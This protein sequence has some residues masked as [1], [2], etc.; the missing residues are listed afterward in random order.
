[1]E[2]NWNR[3]GNKRIRKNNGA[4]AQYSGRDRNSQWLRDQTRMRLDVRNMCS[5]LSCTSGHQGPIRLRR[6]KRTRI[7]TRLR[8]RPMSKNRGRRQPGNRL[9]KRP[10]S[11]GRKRS[12][13]L[14]AGPGPE[15]FG[16]ERPDC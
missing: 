15:V 3:I 6:S 10:H 4:G 1:M 7:P 12:S 11:R 13:H 9:Q 16:T 5:R 14:G 2:A 8:R